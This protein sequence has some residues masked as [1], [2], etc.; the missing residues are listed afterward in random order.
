MFLETSDKNQNNLFCFKLNKFIVCS[1]FINNKPHSLLADSIDSIPIGSIFSAKV[2]KILSGINAAFVDIGLS[3]DAYLE[4]SDVSSLISTT[5][6]KNS[7]EQSGIDLLHEGQH[8]L[9]QLAKPSLD[10]KR[11][12]LTAK[13]KLASSSMV[14]LLDT[15]NKLLFSKKISNTVKSKL[16]PLITEKI[17][18]NHN[19]TSWLVRT[20]AQTIAEADIAA[21]IDALTVLADKL[22]QQLKLNKP[23]L[24]HKAAFTPL[25]IFLQQSSMV[26]Y[27]LFLDAA[28]VDILP[29]TI[30]CSYQIID[31]MPNTI[32]SMLTSLSQH[33]VSLLPKG[34]II[35]ES[36]S[37][38]TAIDVNSSSLS[39]NS[40]SREEF[41]LKINKKAAAEIALQLRLRNIS[42]IIVIDFI[43]MSSSKSYAALLN[44]FSKLMDEDIVKVEVGEFSRMGLLDLSRQCVTPSLKKLGVFRAI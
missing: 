38:L 36:T 9:V 4:V 40:L 29:D 19:Q 24:L 34:S 7:S 32:W 5:I 35:I 11:M 39:C 17:K 30:S 22:M 21:D 15:K 26:D 25:D 28:L 3:E 14:C 37:A 44:F 13:I 43:N 18:S 12:K 41:A 31:K 33:S 20:Q 42:G 10:S 23:S 27:N 8:L 1:K 16:T 2:K 6:T